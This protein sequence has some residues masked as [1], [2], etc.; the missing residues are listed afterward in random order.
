METNIRVQIAWIQSSSQ[1]MALSPEKLGTAGFGDTPEEAL[2]ELKKRIE[3][4]K[5]LKA[6]FTGFEELPTK[7]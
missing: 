6:A 7:E 1:W 2:Q 3:S 5:E 4:Q